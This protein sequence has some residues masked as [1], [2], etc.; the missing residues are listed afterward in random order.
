MKFFSVIWVLL[1]PILLKAQHVISITIDGTIN[2]VAASFIHRS[3]EKAEKANAQCLLIHLNTPGGLLKSTRVIV[4]DILGAPIPVVVYVSPSGAHAG[5]AGV[6]VTLAAHI[7]AMSPGTNIGAA[8]PVSLEGGMDSTMNEKQTNDAVAF[9]R[10]IAQKRARNVDWAEQAVK[11][12]VSIPADDALKLHII[13]LVSPTTRNLLDSLDGR[14]VAL[15][16]GTATLH[17]KNTTIETVQ[18]GFMEKLLNILSDPNIAY[19]MMMLGF[20]GL[21][22]ELYSPG[23]IFPGVVGVI[24]LI[25]AFYAM[26]TLPIN[27]AGV[28]LIIFAL[29]LFILELKVVSHGMLAIG[30]IISLLLGS[31]ML[32]RP[33]ASFEFVRISRS[34]IITSTVVTALFFSFVIGAG[35]RAQRAKPV[36]G[37]EGLQGE[38]GHVLEPLEPLGA[39]LVHGEIWQAE[40]VRGVIEKGRNVRVTG[41]KNLKLFVEPLET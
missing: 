17:T 27:Y 20:Y 11:R 19:I 36:T 8:H 26:H 22:F 35:I 39:V 24:C 31:L 6:F 1:S 10:T 18:M 16:S 4:G 34:V 28:A 2:P 7:A 33:D 38:T 29:F 3:I 37:I 14:T 15:N 30:G 5:S 21:L 23:A 25:L 12:S 9:I 40:S 13:D 41:M 32:V